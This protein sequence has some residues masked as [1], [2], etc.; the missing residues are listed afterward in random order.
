MRSFDVQVAGSGIVGKTLALALARLG[1]SV[2]LR[3]APVQGRGRE[4][5]RAY[6]LNPGSV[7]LLRG[8]KVWDALPEDAR[9]TVHDML[10]HGDAAGAALEFSAWE[11]RVGELAV[12]TDAAARSAAPHRARAPAP[13]RR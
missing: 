9:T 6:A 7:A 12:I 2:A 3:G 11:Q 4:D 13:R 8:L 5:V 10:V 1:L